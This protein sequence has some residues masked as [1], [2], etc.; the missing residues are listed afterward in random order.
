MLVRWRN[1][2]AFVWLRAGPHL[3]G[4]SSTKILVPDI[5]ADTTVPGYVDAVKPPD[6][7]MV[8]CP[9]CRSLMWVGV[10][11]TGARPVVVEVDRQALEFHATYCRG[12]WEEEEAEKAR[13]KAEAY[14]DF[15]I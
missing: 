2:M 14:E 8:P 4:S 5:P 13:A 15:E 9:M 10:T 3:A 1:H 12:R 7:L 6:H 11:V